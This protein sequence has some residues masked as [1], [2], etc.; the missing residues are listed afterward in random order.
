MGVYKNAYNQ[1][2]YDTLKSYIDVLM[3]EEMTYETLYRDLYQIKNIVDEW[4]SD[5]EHSME[6][7]D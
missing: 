5:A 6:M 2:M 4:L 3:Y 1:I 7:E